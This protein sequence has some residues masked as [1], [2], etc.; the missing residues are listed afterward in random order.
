MPWRLGLHAQTQ[1]IG[2][3]DYGVEGCPTGYYCSV[4]VVRSDDPR[5]NRADFAEGTCAYNANDSQSGY[6]AWEGA[7]FEQWLQSRAHVESIK[8]VAEGRADIAAIDAVTWRLAQR[9]D[10]EAKTLRVLER[11][12]PTPGLPFITSKMRDA[13]I[14]ADAVTEAIANLEPSVRDALGLAG[15][16]QI[17]AAD[18][19]A[20]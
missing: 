3:P 19:L 7:E 20:V 4:I 12:R 16:V 10:A 2:T 15:F 1:L 17:P 11:T 13:Q 14:L 9:Y 6:A 5:R 18:Y 8:A